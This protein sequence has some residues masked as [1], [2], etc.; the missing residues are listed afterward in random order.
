MK[1]LLPLLLLT[2]LF[3]CSTAEK[4]EEYHPE[5]I[6]HAGG[7]VDSCIYTN[8]REAMEQALEEGYR[9]VEFDLLFTSDSV[10]VAAHSWSDFNNMTGF[11]H[12]G[13]S[14]PSFSDFS[15]RKIY[16]L[17]TPLSADEINTFFELNEDL[18][19]V[20]DKISEPGVLERYF[21]NLKDRMVV[22]AFS[23]EHYRRLKS[24]GYFRVFYSCMAQDLT[25]TL[26]SSD[27]EN[28]EWL[29]LHTSGF[30]NPIFRLIENI[31]QF[32]IALFTIDNVD[33]IPE[34]YRESV[35]MVY[36]NFIKP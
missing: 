34:K 16:G 3:S 9:F 21:P 7:A 31:H 29:A 1:N 6:A 18:F 30:K 8:S 13:D 12:W 36:T 10:L 22:E 14:V 27:F 11:A 24:E 33:S 26:F 5:Y 23:Y 19:L 25:A 15:A 4:N 32:D 20:T 17:Y 28:V 2:L 35:K